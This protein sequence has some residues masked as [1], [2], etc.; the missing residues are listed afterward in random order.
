L[1]KRGKAIIIATKEKRQRKKRLVTK[2]EKY[3]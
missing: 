1:A 3:L 2:A